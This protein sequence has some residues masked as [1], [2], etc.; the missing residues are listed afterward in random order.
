MVMS[1]DE[2]QLLPHLDGTITEQMEATGLGKSQTYQRVKAFKERLRSLLGEEGRSSCSLGPAIPSTA[3]CTR[4]CP[5][6]AEDADQPS[7]SASATSPS[8]HCR[9]PQPQPTSTSPDRG[10]GQVGEK[11]RWPDR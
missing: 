11:N 2:R 10:I 6:P 3:P 8:T 5:T 9:P 4:P 7:F 1:A